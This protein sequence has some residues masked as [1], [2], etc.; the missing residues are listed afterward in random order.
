[1]SA[2]TIPVTDKSFA[3][4][5]VEASKNG[6]GTGGLLGGMVRSLQDDRTGT[7]RVGG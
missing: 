4:D 5:V 2:N 1:M 6:P 7:E 3:T